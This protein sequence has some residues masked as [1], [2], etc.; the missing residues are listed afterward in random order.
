MTSTNSSLI[1]RGLGAAQRTIQA[2]QFTAPLATRLLVGITF[3]YTGHGKLQ[4][5]DRTALFFSDLG[6]PF[7]GANAIFISSLEF[8]GGICL[9]LGL[10]TRVFAA[11]LSSTMVVA[12]LTADKDTLV[13]KFPA[14]LTDVSPVVLL[15]FL[16]WLVL[17]GGGAASLDRLI[18]RLF[19]RKESKEFSVSTNNIVSRSAA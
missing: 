4:N 2:L 7:P 9:M 1:Q 16:V 10:G 8:F 5:L 3:F 19:K 6:I 17:Y 12:L 15:L 18:S 11:L 13:S 14:D